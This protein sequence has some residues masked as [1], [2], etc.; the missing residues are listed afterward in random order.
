ME[1]SLTRPSSRPHVFCCPFAGG[2][3]AAFRS[4]LNLDPAIDVVGLDYPGRMLR[5]DDPMLLSIDAI[6]DQLTSEIAAQTE[7]PVALFGISLGALVALEIAYRLEE[8][9]RSPV[10][11]VLCA[12]VAPDR[13]P[14]QPKI[15]DAN[16]DV[17]FDRLSKRYGGAIRAFSDDPEARKLIIQYLK[18]DIKTFESYICTERPP[19]KSKIL[20]ATGDQD[21]TVRIS[22]IL[23][24]RKYSTKPVEFITIEGDHFF[25]Q[26]YTSIIAERL[27]QSLIENL[28]A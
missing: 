3:S 4:W 10:C 21:S 26:N 24:W 28:G 17:F 2:S 16:D 23:D 25:A 8:A 11:L 19:L 15:M 5:D 14:R 13:V 6:A 1:T 9:G 18:C 7:A 27:R 20:V 22:D 12:C